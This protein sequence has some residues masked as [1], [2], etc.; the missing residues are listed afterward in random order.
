MDSVGKTLFIPLYGKAAVSRKGIILS[1]PT[2]EQ[3]WEAEGFPVK[4][5]SRSKW[6]AYFMAMRAAVFDNWLRE[7]MAKDREAV[8]LQVGCGLDSRI[9]RVGAGGHRWYDVDFE[10]VIGLRKRFFQPDEQYHMLPGDLREPG[11]LRSI[12]EG[13]NALIALEGISMYLQPEEMQSFLRSAGEHFREVS[14]LMDCY[15]E[16]GARATKVKNPIRD[17]GVTAAYGT[18]DPAVWEQGTGFSFLREHDM[19]PGDLIEQLPG[20]ERFLFRTL[21]GGKVARSLYRLYEF[22][23]TM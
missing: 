7:E 4:R 8:I 10:E 23:K 16:K 22:Q 18:D 6:L 19:T 21:F 11:W 15:T 17:V 2:A 12:P 5:R 1:D 3:I 13:T 9:E 20:A 14:L